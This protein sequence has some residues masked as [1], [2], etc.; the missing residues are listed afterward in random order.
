MR[1]AA[2]KG[3]SAGKLP[4]SCPEPMGGGQNVA[5]GRPNLELFEGLLQS[6]DW[7]GRSTLGSVTTPDLQLLKSK[8]SEIKV[9]S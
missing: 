9:C 3:G 2:A 8:S 7:A 5:A 1:H 4:K 6:E